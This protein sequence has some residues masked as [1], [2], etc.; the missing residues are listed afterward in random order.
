L[1]RV[2]ASLGLGAGAV[3][4]TLPVAAKGAALGAGASQAPHAGG[5]SAAMLAK[6]LAAGVLGGV[7][8]SGTTV[9]VQR[10]R[11]PS[12]PVVVEAPL[13][14]AAPTAQAAPRDAALA[15]N[16]APEPPEVPEPAT[17][18]PL[19]T[20]A[21]SSSDSGGALGAE[22]ARVDAARRALARHDLEQARREL[23]RYQVERSLGVLD[24][25]ALLLRIQVLVERGESERALLLA[26]SYLASHP[27]DAHAESLRAL[28]DHG[29]KSWPGVVGIER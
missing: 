24:R 27:N 12:R 21:A 22:A 23:D 1:L 2:A 26:R 11:A 8:V 28:I 14:K 18:R 10:V 5:A 3:T 15:L 19:A 9:V 13:V 20:V 7:L 4:A 16:P 25:E 6:W 17:V 29:G